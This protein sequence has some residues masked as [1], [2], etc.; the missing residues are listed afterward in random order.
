M[1]RLKIIN[2]STLKWIAIVAMIIDHIGYGFFPELQ[3]FRLIG[4]LAFPIFAFLLTEGYKHTRNKWKY[5][6]RLS[7]F[8]VISEILYD[9][10]FYNTFVYFESQN[11]FFE[12]ALGLLT[13]I[14]IDRSFY[15]KNKNISIIVKVIVASVSCFVAFLCHFSYEHIGIIV[16]ICLYYFFEYPI[17]SSLVMFVALFIRY[18]IDIAVCTII[19]L[20]PIVLYNGKIGVTGKK[21]KWLFY[22]IYPL[23]LLVL[24][25]IKIMI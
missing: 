5:L 23:H 6:A 7:V 3:I 11:I 14:I 20:I 19:A 4:R 25:I 1:N 22:V 8:A 9:Y 18:D 24:S 12:L 10:Y 13:I 21:L 16:I 17:Y 2:A 15:V